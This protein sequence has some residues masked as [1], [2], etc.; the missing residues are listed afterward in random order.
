MQLF[1]ASTALLA[2][3]RAHPSVGLTV[4]PRVNNVKAVTLDIVNAQGA[5]DGA[6]RGA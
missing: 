6:P 2:L 1:F 5:P 4:V 3:L